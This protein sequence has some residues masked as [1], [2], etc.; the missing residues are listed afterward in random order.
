MAS[1]SM[2]K[3]PCA[4]CDLMVNGDG[5]GFG[6]RHGCLVQ[7]LGFWDGLGSRIFEGES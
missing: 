7:G 4:A 5:N 2:S 1:A 3:I 6:N